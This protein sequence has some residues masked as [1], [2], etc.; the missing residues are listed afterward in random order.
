MNG[1]GYISPR[2]TEEADPQAKT[3]LATGLTMIRTGV[4]PM[5]EAALASLTV[6][7]REFV[8][9]PALSVYV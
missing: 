1:H 4:L 6:G 9:D 7:V 8:P 5:Q 2:Q 3:S